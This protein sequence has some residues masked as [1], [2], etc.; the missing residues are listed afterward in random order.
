MTGTKNPAAVEVC[1]RCKIEGKT[2]I[3]WSKYYSHQYWAR[4]DKAAAT[5]GGQ[6]ERGSITTKYF[7]TLEVF[8]RRTKEEMN[9]LVQIDDKDVRKCGDH[10]THVTPCNLDPSRNYVS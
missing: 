6:F 3:G 4:N 7:A 5:S 8:E 10:V 2:P 9:E 1:I